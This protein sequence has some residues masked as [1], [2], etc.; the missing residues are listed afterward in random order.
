[1]KTV[2]KVFLVMFALIGILDSG[3]ITYEELSGAVPVCGAGFDCGKVL[4]SEWSHIGPVPLAAL[5]FFYY[6]VMFCLTSM[7]LLEIEPPVLKSLAKTISTKLEPLVPEAKLQMVLENITLTCIFLI[8]CLGLAFSIFLVSLMAFII[9]AW[10]LYCL[11]SALTSTLLFCT[12]T[13]VVISTYYETT[14]T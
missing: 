13:V 7:Y 1:M 4:R 9:K 6:T 10:C 2:L 8:S 3:Y 11:V 5:G 12:S 14:H